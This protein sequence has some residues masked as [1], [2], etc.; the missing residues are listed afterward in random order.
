MRH[1]LNL[2]QNKCK[3]T[4]CSEA[5]GEASTGARYLLFTRYSCPRLLLQTQKLDFTHH[6]KKEL[7][8]RCCLHSKLLGQ[9]LSRDAPSPK[10]LKT[11]KD[12]CYLL[13]N[14]KRLD[15]PR[16]HSDRIVRFEV[17]SARHCTHKSA[18]SNTK[19]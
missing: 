15:L 10:S 13:S 3:R 16:L 8:V 18:K 2:D 12:S 1:K 14:R 5:Y 11:L 17:C 19:C 4:T 7:R 6:T 9:C